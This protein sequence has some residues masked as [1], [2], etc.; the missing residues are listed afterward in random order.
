MCC[1]FTYTISILVNGSKK[2][3][4]KPSRGIWQGNP[5]S[6]YIFI[7][8]TKLFFRKINHEVD[9]LNWTSIST[10]PGTPKISHLFFADDLTRFAKVDIRKYNTINQ[11]LSSLSLFSGQRINTFKSNI[12][13][14][15]NCNSEAVYSLVSCLIISVKP[16]FA[17]YL[18]FLIFYKKIH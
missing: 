6:L 12:I 11:T 4:F 18:E 15:N 17:K 14:S 2:N 3:F 16:I 8:C 13:F 9:I 7:M 1:I 5:I 10:F